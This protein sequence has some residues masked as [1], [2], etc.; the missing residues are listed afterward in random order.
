MISIPNSP[1]DYDPIGLEPNEDIDATLLQGSYLLGHSYSWTQFEIEPASQVLTV[2]TY[3]VDYY[4]QSELDSDP[5]D[6][7][8]R[9]PAIVSRFV[10]NPQLETG[11]IGDYVWHDAN[12]DRLQDG[13][14]TGLAGVTVY[15]DSNAND[16]RDAGEP[17]AATA[18]GGSY[19]LP[20]LAAG[21]YRV[22][23]DSSTIPAG[24]T[25]TTGNDPLLVTLSAGEAYAAA[26]FGYYQAPNLS[27][28]F[29]YLPLVIKSAD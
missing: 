29:V 2:T 26:D 22:K 17:A 15:L 18:T 25:L 6:I 11:S 16:R 1:V 12:N 7:I 9:T 8:N 23:V 10:V 28:D 19:S 4:T 20:H 3:G 14:E 27:P 5:D 24:Y 13:T 21:S